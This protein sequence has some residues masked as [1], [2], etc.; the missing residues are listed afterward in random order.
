MRRLITVL[1]FLEL[2]DGLITWYSGAQGQLVE[3]NPLVAGIAATW[4]LPLV[5]VLVT[6]FLGTGLIILCRYRPELKPAAGA[7]LKIGCIFMLLV[8]AINIL[9]LQ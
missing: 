7:A 1:L 6:A 8:V 2:A 9:Q 3:A 4:L 5:K